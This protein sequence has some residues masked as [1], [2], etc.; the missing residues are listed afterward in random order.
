MV[1]RLGGGNV[2][3]LLMLIAFITFVNLGDSCDADFIMGTREHR[4][5]R[6]AQ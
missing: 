3:V 1:G 6:Q 2:N 5:L 4:L